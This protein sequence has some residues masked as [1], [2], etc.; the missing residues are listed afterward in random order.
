MRRRGFAT[1]SLSF[2]DAIL[3]GFGAVILLF[4]IVNANSL[5]HRKQVTADLRSETD[6]LAQSLEA[7]RLRLVELQN[8]LR[9]TLQEQ[10]RY[11]GLAQQVNEQ[12][13][14]QQVQL[15]QLQQ[16]NV[17]SRSHVNRLKS[18]LR[19]R[20]E[21]VKRLEAGASAARTQGDRLREHAG[22]GKRQYLTG[23]RLDGRR[24]LV[25]LDASASMLGE[26]IVDVLVRRNLPE[27][28]QR[29]SGKWRWGL[30][31]LD[32]L[33]TQLPLDARFQVYGFNE[34][35]FPL[36]EG[37]AGQW[38]DS[39][40]PEMLTRA[41]K[42]A[43][44]LLPVGGT[45]LLRAF[46]AAQA[47]SPRPD[48][49]VLLTDGLPTQAKGGPTKNPVSGAQRQAH[50]EDAVARLPKGIP[51]NIILFPMEGDPMAAPLFWLLAHQ[52]GGSYFNP[53]RDWP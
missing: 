5:A 51:V 23:M 34:K 31:S 27:A 30:D 10:V 20:E 28:R 52:T 32:W 7:G 6:R 44:A 19:S 46:E 45:N 14:H 50:F 21:G 8:T 42:A 49:I 33:L 24:T 1:F 2:V 25:L 26:R 18:D 3:C 40:N 37:T 53:S 15:A 39:G 29:T 9:E 36:L 13:E 11:E 22:Q 41:A 12:L 43:R 48:N 4:L 35:A 47:F 38:L 16:R 17:A